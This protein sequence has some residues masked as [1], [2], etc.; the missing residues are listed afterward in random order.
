[1]KKKVLVT[2]ACGFIGTHVTKKL[3]ELGY[4][5][6]CVDDMTGADY[7]FFV[8]E[9]D[10]YQ[11]RTVPVGMMGVWEHQRESAETA[12]LVVF[13]G[14]FADPRVIRRLD[15]GI[16][17]GVVHLAA[18]PSVQRSVE[19]P[20]STYENNL[21]KTIELFHICA[22][23]DTKVVF[24]SSAAVYG[25]ACSGLGPIRED[26]PTQP[27]SPYALQKLQCEQVG[28]LF[29]DLY[30]LSISSL[31]FFNVYGPG[32]SGNSPYSTAIASWIDKINQ[33][34][35]LRLDGDGDQTRDYIHVHD[36][37]AACTLALNHDESVVLNIA[38][39]ISVSNNKILT[40]LG[41]Y[42][43]VEVISAP[44]RK[45]DIRHSLAATEKA[46]LKF[47]FVPVVKLRD[48]IAGLLGQNTHE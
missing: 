24:A 14:D 19:Y 43:D 44:E 38:S 47:G 13:E 6:H 5:V 3:I 32:Q 10:D 11:I 33:G 34:L 41:N 22:K 35:P 9:L 42:H 46:T 16:Y 27:M 17:G 4:V 28:S 40:I 2:G 29:S 7:E 15:Q 20:V 25:N 45:G 30:G 8:A 1:M 23:T 12:D 37:A 18:E 48:G 21:Q 26:M 31:R 36:V 39:G